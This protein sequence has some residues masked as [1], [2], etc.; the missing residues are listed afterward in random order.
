MSDQTIIDNCAQSV[1]SYNWT[2]PTGAELTKLIQ[3][4]GWP[5]EEICA[6]LGY[7][8]F[9][10]DGWLSERSEIPFSAWSLLC[11]QVGRS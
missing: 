10:V 6:F 3:D 7:P 11:Y 8:E 1:V 4:I 9:T 5:I 2:A